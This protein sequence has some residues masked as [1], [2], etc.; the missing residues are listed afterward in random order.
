MHRQSEESNALASEDMSLE[1]KKEILLSPLEDDIEEFK[2]LPLWRQQQELLAKRTDEFNNKKK[3]VSPGN[4]KNIFNN[5]IKSGSLGTNPC[6]I[7]EL[8]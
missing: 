2:K 6:S 3:S 1:E 4:L 7:H 8:R 5:D